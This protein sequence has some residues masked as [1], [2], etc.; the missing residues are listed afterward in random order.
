MNFI[1]GAT[2]I[3]EDTPEEIRAATE[4]LL[5][6]IARENNL[7]GDSVRAI[8]F[9]TT[10]DIHSAYPAKAARECGFEKAALFSAAE[11]LIEG[12]LPLCIRVMI[13]AEGVLQREKHVYL[14]KAAALRKDISVGLTI[15]LD[16]PAGSGKSTIAKA[17]A[18]AYDILYLDTGA[19]YRACA[20]CLKRQNI[21][22]DDTLA[23]ARAVA[24]ADI[25]V[26]YEN[27]AQ[28]TLLDGEDVSEEIRKNEISMMASTVAKIGAVREKMVAAQRKI[29]KSQPCVLDGRDIGTTVLPDAPFKFFITADA[30][31]RAQR[32]LKE[33][34]ERGQTGIDLETLTREI[35]ARDEQ[36]KNREISPLR[37][38]A[39]AVVVD[40][41]RLNIEQTVAL[42]REKIQEK[43]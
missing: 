1:R 23:A 29:A 38:A 17:L 37:C 6:A 36:D 10:Q 32:R 34:E 4:E 30:R 20:L 16:G 25:G 22:P 21:S 18:A 11:P 24:A 2:T 31:V 43:I 39:D 8:I 40:T 41:S 19:M 28:C 5:L 12:A 33:L 26:R 27:G 42:I 7:D 14:R 15:A 35:E 9:S 3:T 13:F